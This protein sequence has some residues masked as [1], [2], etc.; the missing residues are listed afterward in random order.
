MKIGED[1]KKIHTHFNSLYEK[2]FADFLSKFS[3]NL[4]QYFK[5][6]IF[7]LA[8]Q[9][10][11]IIFTDFKMENLIK[12]KKDNTGNNISQQ[13]FFYYKDF[14]KSLNLSKVE[15]DYVYFELQ[16]SKKHLN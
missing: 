7:L 1:L 9:R 4:P 13:E 3:I 6:F 15:S 8:A 16:K 2:S 12:Q 11:K 5:A 10:Q 14:E